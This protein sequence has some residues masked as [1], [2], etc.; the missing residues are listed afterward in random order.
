MRTY[1]QDIPECLEHIVSRALQKEPDRRYGSGL[2]LAS[3]LSECYD[4]I[5]HTDER[6]NFQERLNALNK[7]NFFRDFTRTELNEVLKATQWLEYEAGSIIITEGEIDDCFYI[8]VLGE[9]AVSKGEKILSLLKQGDCF[10]EMAY[11]GK[12]KRTANIKAL[13]KS[14]L[15]KITASLMEEASL[16][17]QNRFFKVL[18]QTL[19]QRLKCANQLI[20]KES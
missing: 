3:D 13:K 2:E 4:E 5:R 11:L 7:L 8:I 15:M 20:S 9:V 17:T 18:L 14:V 19:I 1:R 10:G 16:E 6:V 12:M